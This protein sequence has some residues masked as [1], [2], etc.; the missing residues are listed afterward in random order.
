MSERKKEYKI[1]TKIIIIK[2]R[3]EE[4]LNRNNLRSMMCK[5]EQFLF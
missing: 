4:E 2:K 5:S 1:E 3:E